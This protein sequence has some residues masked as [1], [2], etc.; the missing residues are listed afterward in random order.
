MHEIGSI[1]YPQTERFALG[2]TSTKAGRNFYEAPRI[3]WRRDFE[4]QVIFHISHFKQQ[5]V[6][7]NPHNK[8][9]DA[10]PCDNAQKNAKYPSFCCTL[11]C[12]NLPATTKN[13]SPAPQKIVNSKQFSLDFGLLEPIR[14][15]K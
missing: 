13:E 15:K 7:Q 5:P 3:F 6:S 4:Q 12:A 2:L 10:R 11:A 8:N 14:S 9:T 1:Q